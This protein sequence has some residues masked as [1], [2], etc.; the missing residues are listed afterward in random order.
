MTWLLSKAAGSL[1]SIVILFLKAIAR[2]LS[3][4]RLGRL[5]YSVSVPRMAEH[6]VRTAL[7]VLG[8]AVGVALLVAVATVNQSIIRGVADTVQDISGKA[9]L[10]VGAGASGFD[11]SV[12]AQIAR[13]PGVAKTT[14]TLQQV[15]TLQDPRA[16]S[17]RLLLV[18][19]DLLDEEEAYFH[20][21]HSPDVERIREDP[22]PFLNGTDH[23][24]LSSALAKRLGYQVGDR[25]PVTTGTGLHK[26]LVFGLLEGSSLGKAL[27]APSP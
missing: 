5:L 13:V 6:R 18:G 10:E 2:L 15:T 12:R 24:L 21:D 9:D 20:E 16:R 11:E 14:M 8:I 23:I 1:G 26:L 22:L 7:T 4:L 27:A 25:V 17:E 19:I 3:G